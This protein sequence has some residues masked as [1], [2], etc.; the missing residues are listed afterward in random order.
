V[1]VNDCLLPKLEIGEWIMFPDLGAYTIV[2]ASYF[3]SMTKP[4]CYYVLP[5]QDWSVDVLITSHPAK[6]LPCYFAELSLLFRSAW[7]RATLQGRGTKLHDAL[8]K[9]SQKK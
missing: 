9:V 1:V 7:W 2:S 4:K 5:Q 8:Y 6:D 3:N